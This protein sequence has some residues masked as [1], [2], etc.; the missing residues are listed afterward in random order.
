MEAVKETADAAQ[1]AHQTVHELPFLA[2]HGL[3]QLRICSSC[4]CDDDAR[5]MTTAPTTNDAAIFMTRHY[6]ESM[7]ITCLHMCHG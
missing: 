5:S 1:L 6:S 7:R 4:A 3:P 2:R